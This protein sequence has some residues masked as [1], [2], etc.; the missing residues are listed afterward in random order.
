[1][2]NT[3]QSGDLWQRCLFVYVWTDENGGFRI[4][5]YHISFTT[6]ITHA[7]WGILSYSHCLAFSYGRAKTIRLRY[8]WTPVFFKT[9]GKN[10]R[11]NKYLDTYGRDLRTISWNVFSSVVLG[12]CNIQLAGSCGKVELSEPFH[13]HAVERIF[14]NEC[15]CLP[16]KFF[17]FGHQTFNLSFIWTF[18]IVKNTPDF[19]DN[20]D[21]DPRWRSKDDFTSWVISLGKTERSAKRDGMCSKKPGVGEK[22]LFK[23]SNS[24]WSLIHA[25]RSFS[26]AS[27]TSESLNFF[28]SS[29]P[30]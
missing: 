24:S 18:Q 1:M 29:A 23:E 28:S 16:I 21:V 6:R 30:R 5:W 19:R 14:H 12:E 11:F 2:K 25:L 7:L 8:E 26:I 27:C 17:I 3:L 22:G 13:F 15:P 9:E 10:L 4:R 20:G